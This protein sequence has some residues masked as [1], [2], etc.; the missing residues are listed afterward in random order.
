MET[1]GIA[2]TYTHSIQ[3]I[4]SS[5]CRFVDTKNWAAL[6][7]L[8]AEKAKMMFLDEEGEL[9]YDFES[10]ELLARSAEAAIGKAV[11][12]HHLHNPE[13]T[14]INESEV[15]GIWSMEDRFYLP[16][17]APH[18]F[19]HGAGYYQIRFILMDDCWKINEL[20]LMRLR[21]KV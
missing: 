17:N 1:N 20:Q 15:V 9:L 7:T 19:F 21:L 13:V 2:S 8:F 3:N 10:A 16:A 5:Y 12:L 6:Q 11:T 18:P 4:M 14:L